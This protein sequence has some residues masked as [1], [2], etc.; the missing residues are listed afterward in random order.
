MC[1]NRLRDKVPSI[2]LMPFAVSGNLKAQACF[3]P[4]IRA[5]LAYIT[6]WPSTAIS[7][8]TAA[9]PFFFHRSK[10]V[11]LVAANRGKLGNP[12]GGPECCPVVFVDRAVRAPDKARASRFP[13]DLHFL[14]SAG[15]DDG[16]EANGTVDRAHD[17]IE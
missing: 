5:D 3:L 13:R 7:L 14:A 1:K 10:N 2:R 8:Q 9:S 17:R 11:V 4:G 15:P 12:A 16:S 6:I